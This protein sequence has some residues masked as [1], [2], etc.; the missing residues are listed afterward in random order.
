MD[1]KDLFTIVY[2]TASRETATFEG[3]IIKRLKAAAG[4]IPIIS[5]SQKPLDLGKNICVGDIGQTGNNGVLQAYMGAKEAKTPY[6]IL[7]E[8]DFLYPPEY[9]SFVPPEL[10]Q[11][12]RYDNIRIIFDTRNK[13]YQKRFSEGAQICGREFFVKTYREFLDQVAAT[14]KPEDRLWTPFAT[15]GWKYFHGDTPAVS[16]KT[17]NG[18]SFK[19]PLVTKSIVLTELPYWGNVATLKQ[20][21]YNE[22]IN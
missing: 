11:C 17:R 8:S 1:P 6:V 18:V 5:V 13:A 12:Y 22:K 21:I 16:F 20:T 2:Y 10:D 14:E 19:C 7:A 9:F 4:E 15:L 3:N